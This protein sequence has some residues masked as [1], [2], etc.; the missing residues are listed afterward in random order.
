[1]TSSRG[2]ADRRDRGADDN[3]IGGVSREVMR[4]AL[5]QAREAGLHILANGE[6]A[7][8]ARPDMSLYAPRITTLKI[9][10]ENPRLIDREGSDSLDRR[11]VPAPRSTSRTTARSSWP[12]PMATR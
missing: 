8:E 7:L 11:G 2:L 5:Y 12:R 3:K 6:D 1:M 10:P 9:R 4:D